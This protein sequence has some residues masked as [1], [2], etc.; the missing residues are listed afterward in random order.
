MDVIKTYPTRVEADLDKIEL[1]AADI[2]C[3]IIGIDAAMEG[4][5]AGVRLLVPRDQVERAL[6][7]LEPRR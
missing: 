5:I 7:I 4:G 1:E 2:P 3:V 6:Q